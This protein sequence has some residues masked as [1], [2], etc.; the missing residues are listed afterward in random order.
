MKQI[1]GNQD[2]SD[3]RES[4]IPELDARVQFHGMAAGGDAVGRDETGRVVFAPGAAP[5][6]IALVRL[7][8]ATHFGREQN[9]SENARD[10]SAGNAIRHRASR[11]TKTKP[12]TPRAKGFAR[13]HLMRLEAASPQRVAPP[14]PFYGDGTGFLNRA[15]Q[16]ADFI[17]RAATLGAVN[18]PRADV[19]EADVDEAD[20]DENEASSSGL[21]Q[22]NFPSQ[23]F[24]SDKTPAAKSGLMCGG[25]QWQH[26]EYAAQLAAKTA[27]VR[28]A[29]RRIGG[30]GDAAQ[31]V[32]QPCAA[33]PH[34][35]FYRNKAEFVVAPAKDAAAP[36]SASPP[37]VS[38]GS[39]PHMST[40]GAP[41]QLQTG[42]A[43]IGFYARESHRVVDVTRCLIQQESNNSLLHAAREAL[44][45]ELAE[46]FDE[47]SG[48]GVLK[49][50]VARAA[51]D[52]DALLIVET[53]GNDW[54]GEVEFASFMRSR[55]PKLAGVLRREPQP[56]GQSLTNDET[57]LQSHQRDVRNNGSRREKRHDARR[58]EN[59]SRLGPG[60][61][62]GGADGGRDWIEETVCDLHLRATGDSFFQINTSLTPALV[63]AALRLAQVEAGS[64]AIDL[65][66]G[67]GL[68]TLALA[69]AGA[70][71]LGIEEHPGAVRDARENARRNN[72]QATWMQGDAARELRCMSTHAGAG[73]ENNARLKQ[74]QTAGSRDSFASVLREKGLDVLLLDPP[75]AGAAECV[76]EIAL[77]RPRRIVYVSCDPSTLARDVKALG[78]RGYRVDCA[79]PFD[80][81]PQTSHVE[82][83]ARLIPS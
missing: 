28:E 37:A 38:P 51:S 78:A 72:L 5:G 61:L 65:F 12:E 55:V 22:A 34:P 58:S 31:S 62:I 59:T 23:H 81:F 16:N 69:R 63:E 67:V 56:L 6:D 11:N 29:L 21:Q 57:H 47:H 80:L 30:L 8:D 4:E 46:P 18:A 49:R 40:H 43:L 10:T 7:A 75:R 17:D 71:V 33:S 27:L 25:C 82:T 83:V 68:F 79:L 2:A 66:C 39:A 19:D 60:R 20:V 3:A 32:V 54:P 1:S 76:R 35:F 45:S 53:S 44:A 74:G 26:V 15:S 48:R 14:C 50:L 13:G 9:S 42:N 70:H 73:R 52:G 64:V 36:K 41:S 24:V 77:L